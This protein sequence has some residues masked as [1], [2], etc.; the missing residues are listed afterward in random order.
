MAN[1]L[2][3]AAAIVAALIAVPLGAGAA[4]AAPTT[5][6]TNAPTSAPTNATG[7]TSSATDPM[8]HAKA[9]ARLAHERTPATRA[10]SAPSAK[11]RTQAEAAARTARLAGA[12]RYDTS[13]AV[14]KVSYDDKQLL[15]GT[16]IVASGTQFPDAVAGGPAAAGVGGPMLLVPPTGTVPASVVTEIKRLGVAAVYIM[17]SE[18]A[19]SAG[20]EAQIDAIPGVDYVDRVFGAD[21]Y[22]TA[23]YASG[24]SFTFDETNPDADPTPPPVVY[25]ASGTTFADSLS[26]SA[27]GAITGSPLLLTAPT[28]LPEVTGFALQDID[29]VEVRI[30]GSTAAVSA[31]VA[32]QVAALVPN[33]KITRLGGADRY[34]TAAAV[35]DNLKLPTG[36]V[37]MLANGLNF[38]DALSASTSSAVVNAP[39][40]LVKQSCSP[41]ATTAAVKRLAPALIRAIGSTA[42]VSNNALALK[43]C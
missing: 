24:L 20:V 23:A 19:V 38:P 27:A 22:E 10:R 36:G 15:G 29:P 1:R 14:S 28:S 25:L 34:A 43:G 30:L 13:V 6:P 42:V 35:S 12:N 40:L 39:L 33:A 7:S 11:T 37:V 32:T 26:G 16:M 17:G 31:N 3:K 9:L 5:A 41:A 21:R 4:T 18:G 8:A 2:P